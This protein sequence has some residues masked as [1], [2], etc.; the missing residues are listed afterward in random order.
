[1]ALQF[2][3]II[4][5]VA[6]YIAQIASAAIPAFTA[7]SDAAKLDPVLAKQ[8]EELQAAAT[9]NSQSIQVLADKMQQAIEGIESA[10]HDAKKQI[11]AYRTML[12]CALALSIASL[13]T[14]VYLLTR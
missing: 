14:S 1:M 11:A 4:K 6:P 9:H 5:A 8:I 10:A 3:P 2:L 13:G 7:K 12:I